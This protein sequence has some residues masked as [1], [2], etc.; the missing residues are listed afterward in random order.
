MNQ[1]ISWL[2]HA[3]KNWRTTLSGICMTVIGFSAALSTPNPYINTQ[4]AHY[5]LAVSSI[6][7]LL[8]HAAM[9]DGSQTKIILPTDTPVKMTMPAGS[10]VQQTTSISVPQEKP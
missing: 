4:V 10:Q 5:A 1:L 8:L 2:S 6:A 7:T 9:T 3:S